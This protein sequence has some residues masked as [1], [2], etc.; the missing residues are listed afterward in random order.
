M[1]TVRGATNF[2][3][4]D[5]RNWSCALDYWST[6]SVR[7]ISNCTALELGS[8]G[9]GLSLW[10]ALRGAH[11][12]CSDISLETDSVRQFHAARGVS[13]LIQ[14]GCINATEIPYTSE[15]DIV[16]FKSVL[17][18]IGIK[19]GKE[20]QAKAIKE[21]HKALK[22]GGELF[23]AENLTGS[24][25]HQALRRRFVGWGQRWRY[26]TLRE[27]QEFLS[28][29]SAVEYRALGVTGAFGRTET[30]RNVLGMLD[31]TILN[32]I[33]PEAC[34]YIVVGIARK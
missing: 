25:L 18:Y 32:H 7:D 22:P 23:F 3:G 26:V 16:V 17:G 11:V 8:G 20:L 13:H 19:G 10:L 9:G 28:P 30:Q 31:Q 12:F 33:L 5:V 21:M 14:Y 34:R 1:K 24:W 6:H 15:F 2:I 4:W 29:F 27:M